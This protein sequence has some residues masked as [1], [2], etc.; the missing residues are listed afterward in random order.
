MGHTGNGPIECTYSRAVGISFKINTNE[1]IIDSWKV[2]YS[3]FYVIFYFPNLILSHH[4]VLLSPAS[5]K[6][7]VGVCESMKREDGIA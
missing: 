3:C 7:I 4:S 1:V 6:V 5:V 2:T